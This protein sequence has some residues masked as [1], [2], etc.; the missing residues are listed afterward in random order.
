MILR[1][2]FPQSITTTNC[3]HHNGWDVPFITLEGK[4]SSLFAAD[5]IPNV[6]IDRWERHE[7]VNYNDKMRWYTYAL[8]VATSTDCIPIYGFE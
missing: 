4:I 8:L 2:W 3:S 6:T 5:V 7:T 1:F